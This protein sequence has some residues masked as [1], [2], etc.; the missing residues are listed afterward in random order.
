MTAGKS[1]T[2]SS[3][4]E[5]SAPKSSQAHQIPRLINVFTITDANSSYRTC[6]RRIAQLAR[7]H[8]R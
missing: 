5:M 8:S 2:L 7:A 6:G 3:E 4:A 1:G